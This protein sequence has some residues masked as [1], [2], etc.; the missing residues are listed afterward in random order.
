MGN[1]TLDILDVSIYKNHNRFRNDKAFKGVKMT[2][3]A[4]RRLKHLRFLSTLCQFYE[5]LPLSSDVLLTNTVLYLPTNSVLQ[6]WLV[7]HERAFGL[8]KRVLGLC[9]H[10]STYLLYRIKLGHFW[11]WAVFNFANISRLWTLTQALMVNLHLSFCFHK[12]LLEFLP[13]SAIGWLPKDYCLSNVLITSDLAEKETIS[14]LLSKNDFPVFAP[15]ADHIES[16]IGLVVERTRP[17]IKEISKKQWLK[18]TIHSK[19]FGMCKTL[20]GS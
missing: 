5:L 4:I 9:Q 17:E 12:E 2:R 7:L 15:R 13:K 18:V 16:T 1:S 14:T 19:K 10:T 20:K 8:C 6:H 3:K 11:N